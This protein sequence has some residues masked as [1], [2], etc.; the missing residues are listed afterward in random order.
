MDS[1][2][3]LVIIAF[4]VAIEMAIPF[5]AKRNTVFGVYI[6]DEFVRDEKLAFF[7]KM[8]SLLILIIGLIAIG[9]YLLLGVRD[10]PLLGQAMQFSIIFISLALYFFFHAKT[11]Q[12]KKTMKWGENLK[13]VKVTDF[14]VR[15]LDEMLPWYLYLLPIAV[16]LGVIGYTLMNYSMLPEQIPTHWGPSGKPDAF[17]EKNLFSSI[18]LPV[19]LL[20][21][22]FMFI[23]INESTRR[24]GIKLSATRT[25]A[26][27][28]RQLTLRKYSS[29]FMFFVN[30]LVTML[31][32]FLQ[33]QMIHPN[34]TDGVVLMAI[35]IV[36]ILI[37]LICSVIFAVKVGRAGEKIDNE[38][39]DGIS[40]LDEDQYWIGGMIYFNKNDPSIF[41]EK[42]FGIGWTINFANPLGY[43]LMFVPI[44]IILLISW[45]G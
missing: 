26:S 3:F 22:Q 23:G 37:I 45:F 36:F 10:N 9:L 2:L 44:V 31:F 42:R 15:S 40:D 35:P 18:S 8:Y 1:I 29:W 7:K 41:V 25:E 4:L 24:S 16:S 19:I 32:S 27:R 30:V 21:L 20:V 43:I 5:L 28:I 11:L 34:I 39:G 13:Q 6:P 14:S 38:Y 12:R 17:T 33:L